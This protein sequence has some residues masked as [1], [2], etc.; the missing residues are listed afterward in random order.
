MGIC[1]YLNIYVLVQH[2]F[3]RTLSLR[4]RINNIYTY[5]MCS[6]IMIIIGFIFTYAT[7]LFITY[8]TTEK[9]HHI[10]WPVAPLELQI[11]GV[12]VW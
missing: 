5:V 6:K 2:I 12:A 9:Y 10:I 7:Q 11:R 4:F 3:W 8:D 1:C